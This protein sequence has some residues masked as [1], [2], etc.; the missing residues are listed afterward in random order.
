MC[1]LAEHH[2]LHG[3]QKGR[4]RGHRQGRGQDGHGGGKRTGGTALICMLHRSLYT[5]DRV[6]RTRTCWEQ[7]CTTMH[8]IDAMLLGVIVVIHHDM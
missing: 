8:A 7:A 5:N 1:V 2:G 3:G 4:G 6:T